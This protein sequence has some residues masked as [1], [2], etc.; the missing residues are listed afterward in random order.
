MSLP[1][2]LFSVI[3]AVMVPDTPMCRNT[4]YQCDVET[5]HS[6]PIDVHFPGVKRT[7]V[8]HAVLSA[9]D[10]KRTLDIE[11]GGVISQDEDL[12]RRPSLGG[13]KRSQCGS[14]PTR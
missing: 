11:W 6:W 13:P 12:N 3:V 7:L 5:F 14:V 4:R 9:F 10:P 8:R 1:A 2:S